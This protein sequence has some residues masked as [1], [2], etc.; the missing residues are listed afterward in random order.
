MRWAQENARL[1][2]IDLAAE[3]GY[4]RKSV[5]RWL[6]D[7]VRPRPIVLEKWAERCGVRYQW[8][9][10]G[11]GPI[12]LD[13]TPTGGNRPKKATGSRVVPFSDGGNTGIRCSR[14]TPPDLPVRVAA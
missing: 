11:M 2:A 5:T 13:P 14:R 1:K 12:L 10:T 4:D 8:L 9:A 7:E 6:H 3:F